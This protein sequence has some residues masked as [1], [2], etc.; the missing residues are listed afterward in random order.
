M[1]ADARSCRAARFGRNGAHLGGGDGGPAVGRIVRSLARA[2]GR[3]GARPRLL[4]VRSDLAASVLRI[5]QPRW[6]CEARP[7]RRYGAMR[8]RMP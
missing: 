5:P 6:R 4:V 2:F 1:A 3:G 7:P 8:W